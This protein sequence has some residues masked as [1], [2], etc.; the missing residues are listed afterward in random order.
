MEKWIIDTDAGVDDAQALILA[1]CSNID[2]VAIT[3]VSGNTPET[4]VYK[5]VCE[6]LRVCDKDTQIYRGATRPIINQTDYCPDYHGE[7]GLNN[8]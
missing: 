7:D 2:V 4:N 1:L 3:T 6:I 5:N 8:Y